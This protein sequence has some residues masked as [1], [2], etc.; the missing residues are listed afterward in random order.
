MPRLPTELLVRAHRQDP[1]LPLLL[2]ECRDLPSARNELRWLRNHAVSEASGV[3]FRQRRQHINNSQMPGWRTRLR[4]MC[5]ARAKG[6][7][8]QYILGDQP[9][10]DLEIL[11][12]EGV[13][14][15][16][17]ETET[18]TLRA[19]RLILKHFRRESDSQSIV[20][21]PK[22][23][24]RII[25]LCTGT[26][27]IPLLLH[28]LL[29]PHVPQ[30]EIV[31]VDISNKA[32]SLAKRN[33]EHNV[34]LGLLSKRSRS[35][36]RFL[37]SNVLERNTHPNGLENILQ[38]TG[39]SCN[40]HDA[41]DTGSKPTTKGGSWDVLISNPPYISPTQFGNGTTAR[42]VRVYEPKLALVP[43]P[44]TNERSHTEE[45]MTGVPMANDVN[46]R[47]GFH[48]P[49]DTFYPRLIALSSLLN[50]KLTIFECGDPPQA[51]RVAELAAT[52]RPASG[53]SDSVTDSKVEVWR[54]DDDMGHGDDGEYNS[55][56]GSEYT[57]HDGGARAVVIKRRSS[58]F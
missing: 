44:A 26:G 38:I 8:L 49:A 16:R 20:T 32:L 46:S 55:P 47:T 23:P 5:Q 30:L 42:S 14:I 25:D 34:K 11:C 50:A 3:K 37:K 18:Y 56:S 35:E 21:L 45:A 57:Q 1:L 15:P 19:A 36:V 33:L 31:G 22:G 53:K 4:S 7:P 28:Q 54:C 17:S 9:F 13:L 58:W 48:A 39:D 10:G 6:K 40:L 52:Y 2:R 29:S 24:L 41:K 43:P 27:C 12:R 51:L